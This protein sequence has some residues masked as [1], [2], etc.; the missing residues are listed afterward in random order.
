QLLHARAATDARITNV[1]VMGMGEPLLNLD[2]LL[3]ALERL[4]DPAG[5]NLGARRITVST[6]GYPDRIRR[7]AAVEHAYNL[8]VS[9][10][11]ADDALRRK[12]VPT[13]RATVAE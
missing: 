12:L 3:P 1:V 6:S 8:A 2:A 13:A 4:G 9:L 10:H 7:L 11:A 5:I